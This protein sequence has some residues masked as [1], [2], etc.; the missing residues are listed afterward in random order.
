MVPA[1]QEEES[2]RKLSFSFPS[3]DQANDVHNIPKPSFGQI[4]PVEHTNSLSREVDEKDGTCSIIHEIDRHER[5]SQASQ[6]MNVQNGVHV[7]FD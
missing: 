2:V 5:H 6:E 1:T 3:K 4:D 7:E